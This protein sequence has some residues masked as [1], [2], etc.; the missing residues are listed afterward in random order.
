[1]PNSLTHRQS[2]HRL[3]TLISYMSVWSRR[4]LTDNVGIIAAALSAFAASFTGFVTLYFTLRATQRSREDARRN[5]EDTQFYEAMK[6][7]GDKD[8][9]V[10]RAGADPSQAHEGRGDRERRAAA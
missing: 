7:F 6:R 5:Q 9:P 2:R 1:M 4:K 3:V 10:I 8:S